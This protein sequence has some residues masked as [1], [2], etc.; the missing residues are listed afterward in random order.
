MFRHV[1]EQ[2]NSLI[3]EWCEMFD[4]PPAPMITFSESDLGML[5]C[6]GIA[7]CEISKVDL[8]SLMYDIEFVLFSTKDGCEFELG[9]F[10]RFAEPPH[11]S[12]IK[13]SQT[14]YEAG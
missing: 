3:C 8:E 10:W 13:K 5:L 12:Y 9:I 1:I 6:N 4:D 14:L 7:L 11:L 2:M